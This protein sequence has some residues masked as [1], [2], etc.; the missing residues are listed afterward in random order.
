LRTIEA[1]RAQWLGAPYALPQ[2]LCALELALQPPPQVVLAGDPRAGDF[3]ALAAV[4][5]ERPGPR[6]VRLCADGGPGQ[7]WLAARVPELAA[8]RPA[9]G[10]AMAYVCENFTCRQP[11]NDAAAL[12]ALLG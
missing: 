4:L 12:R 1:F 5:H 6:R 3:R 2:M 7:A 11:V 10:R 8:M 9:A